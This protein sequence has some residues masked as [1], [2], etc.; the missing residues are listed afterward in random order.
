MAKYFWPA[1]ARAATPEALGLVDPAPP[2]GDA[3]TAANGAVPADRGGQ[4]ATLLEVKPTA[5]AA[6]T[7]PPVELPAKSSVPSVAAPVAATSS[8]LPEHPVT[9]RPVHRGHPVPPT[10]SPTAAATAV[11]TSAGDAAPM[12]DSKVGTP[13]TVPQGDYPRCPRCGGPLRPDVVFFGEG[14]PAA[15]AECSTVDMPQCNL[16]LVMGTSLTVG[17]PVG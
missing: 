7:S 3:A 14:L 6:T 1:I 16:L 13:A 5:A 4:A 17:R 8:L 10:P 9:S 2:E 15:F 11:T 12:S